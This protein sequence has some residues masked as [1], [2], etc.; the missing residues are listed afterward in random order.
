MSAQ[1]AQVHQP[2]FRPSDG[3]LDPRNTVRKRLS[4]AEALLGSP[5][6][7][8]PWEN[9]VSGQKSI[10]HGHVPIDRANY[11]V[12]EE[13]VHQEA[14]IKSVNPEIEGPNSVLAPKLGT[15]EIS[16]QEV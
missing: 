15:E 7:D 12:L 16:R 14:S 2:G 11:G 13:H 6:E 10:K 9:E 3:Y 1:E 8:I 5:R 4:E